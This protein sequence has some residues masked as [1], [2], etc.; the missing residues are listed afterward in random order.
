MEKGRF[1]QLLVLGS[2]QMSSVKVLMNNRVI[3]HTSGKWRPVF[4]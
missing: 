4:G 3:L 1:L 2:R